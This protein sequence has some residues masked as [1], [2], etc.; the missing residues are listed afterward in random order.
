M[1]WLWWWRPP[2]LLRGVILN[3]KADGVAIRGVLW[4]ARGPWLTLRDAALLKA[5]AGTVP[6]PVD[7][8]IVVHRANVSFIQVLP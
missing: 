1:R 8:E 3:L 4:S 2:C 6:T 7:G 5:D